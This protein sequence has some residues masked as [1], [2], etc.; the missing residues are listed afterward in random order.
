MTNKIK[1]LRKSKK[2]SGEELGKAIGVERAMMSKLERGTAKLTQ[3]YIEKLCAALNVTSEQLLGREPI[4]QIPQNN[5]IIIPQSSQGNQD[6]L[7]SI[8]NPKIPVYGAA[9]AGSPERI[10]LTADYII[11][12]DDMPDSLTGVKDAFK[13]QIAGDSMEPRYYAG[14]KA[15]IHPYKKPSIGQDCVLVDKEDGNAIIKRYMGETSTEYK[16]A[17]YNPPKAFTIKKSKIRSIYTV[18]GRSQ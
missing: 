12:W 6:K 3:H 17:Q 16:V 5:A 4:A 1:E 15:D 2:L 13:I 9:G 18:L 7:S 11:E 14:E 8:G 10:I